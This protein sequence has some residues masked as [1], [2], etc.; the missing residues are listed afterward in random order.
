MATSPALP[1]ITGNVGP[2]P[3]SSAPAPG[4]QQN[5]LPLLPGRAQQ[6]D[7]I[8]TKMMANGESDASI[9][10]VVHD[11]KSLY[12]AGPPPAAPAPSAPPPD[13]LS[14]FDKVSSFAAGFDKQSLQ[15]LNP[16]PLVKALLQP[17]DTYEADAQ[18]R[19]KILDQ[20]GADFHQGNYGSAAIH[21]LDGMVP[22][23]GPMIN[24]I[25][26]ASDAGDPERFGRAVANLA[27]FKTA[28][29]ALGAA[30]SAVVKGAGAA[31]TAAMNAIKIEPQL[32]P[33]EASAVQYGADNGVQMPTSVQTGSKVAANAENILQNLP[34]ASGVAK[35]ARAEETR[36]LG[37]AGANEVDQLGAQPGTNAPVPTKLDAGEAL[38]GQLDQ[39]IAEHHAAAGASYDQL[40]SIENQPQFKANV[41]TGTKR[42]EAGID[43][44]GNP[45]YKNVPV[46][47]DVQLPVPLRPVK[48]ALKP[49]YDRMMRQMP[50]AQQQASAGL[51][52]LSNIVNGPDFESASIT[53]ENLGAIKQIA[54][55]ATSPVGQGLAKAA[56]KELDAAVRKAVAR[57]GPD[58]T[59]ALE[60]GRAST[61]AK[62]GA[63]EVKDSLPVEPV[64][65]VTK[66][67]APGDRNIKLLRSV[68]EQSPSHIASLAQAAV[69]GLL[70]QVTAEAGMAKA[71]T[72]LTAWQKLGPETKAILFKGREKGITDFFTL[73]KKMAENP[74]PSGTASVVALGKAGLLLF[75]KPLFA[76]PMLLSS[77]ALARV[78]FTPTG[79][80]NLIAGMKLPLKSGAIGA[81][82]SA[83][84][85]KAAGEPGPVRTT[86]KGQS[87]TAENAA[88]IANDGPVR[89]G[90]TDAAGDGGAVSAPAGGRAQGSGG[91]G[92]RSAD[93]IVPVPGKSGAGYRAEYKLRELSDI[94]ASHNGNSFSPNPKYALQN[95]RDYANVVNQRKV[96]DWS[97]RAEFRPGELVNDNPDATSGPIVTD[98]QGQV[99]GGNGRKMILDRVH[100]G[101]PDGAAAYRALLKA[102]AEQF[103]LDPA[104]VDAM[105]QPVLTRE[106]A[107]AAL[108]DKQ[109]AVTDF[110]KKGTADLTPGERAIADSRRV[111]DATLDD[112]AARLDAAGPKATVAD[113]LAGKAGGEALQKL[114]ADGVISPQEQASLVDARS[115]ELTKAGRE[116]ISQLMI[117]R[118]FA[119][120]AQLDRMALSA[121][122]KLERIAAPL[123]QVEAKPAWNLTPDVR[124]AV[125][126]SDQARKL[127]IKSVADFIAQDGLFGKDKY[128]PNAIILAKAL[129]TS[130]STELTAAARQYA[131]DAAYADKGPTLMG[132]A[133]TPK[134]SFAA[135]FGALKSGAEVDAAKVK[136]GGAAKK[137]AAKAS[138]APV[139]PTVTE[140]K[141][142]TPPATDKALGELGDLGKA[143]L[144]RFVR[145]R[146]FIPEKREQSPKKGNNPRKKDPF[147]QLFRR[148]AL[149]LVFCALGRHASGQVAAPLPLS[150]I[151]FSDANGV[152]LAGGLVYTC[153]AGSSC[154]GAPLTSYSNATGTA[155]TNPIVLNSGGFGDFWLGVAAYK[156]VVQDLNGVQQ[157]SIDNITST[158]ALAAAAL[159]FTATGTGAVT[160]TV[161][162]KL[163][164]IVNGA[165]Y[166]MLCNG[167]ADDQPAL[168]RAISAPNVGLVMLP[169]SVSGC[170]ISESV[171]LKYGVD[172]AGSSPYLSTLLAGT[173]GMTMLSGTVASLSTLSNFHLSAGNLANV[174]G[175]SLV[176]TT[177]V[178][179]RDIYIDTGVSTG[180]TSNNSYFLN[181]ENV[182][183][184]GPLTY[185]FALD[186]A[187]N[188]VKLHQCSVNATVGGIV[189]VLITNSI[190][191]SVDGGTFEGGSYFLAYN[192]QA[193][194]FTNNYF[195]DSQGLTQAEAWI[196][197]GGDEGTQPTPATP[198]DNLTANGVAITGNEFNGG[199]NYAVK[200]GDVS[201]V[202][203]SGN[204]VNTALGAWEMFAGGSAYKKGIDIGANSYLGG[205]SN[206][207]GLPSWYPAG[208]VVYNGNPGTENSLETNI[209]EDKFQPQVHHPVAEPGATHQDPESVVVYY[210]TTF[211]ALMGRRMDSSGNL[212]YS[213]LVPPG[214]GLCV[215]ARTGVD[216]SPVSCFSYQT[217]ANG[218]DGTQ[219]NFYAGYRFVSSRYGALANFG[220]NDTTRS[221]YFST[222]LL[223]PFHN[224][225]PTT[226]TPTVDIYDGTATTG[227]T[228]LSMRFGAG[229]GTNSPFLIRNAADTAWVLRALTGGGFEVNGTAG[230]SGTKTA[231]SCVL[232]LVGGVVTTITGC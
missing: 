191:V 60:Q 210:D 188:S 19:I 200:L 1:T 87:T 94:Q 79:A 103:G 113:V 9:T 202:S 229:Q 74:N 174:T 106:I 215:N 62:Y 133:P 181:L 151:Q 90:T 57:A 82:V 92:V 50:V 218:V 27:S 223:G 157:Y 146:P 43:E 186:A 213:T 158:A 116:R 67:L 220:G 144:D 25:G 66:L 93:T 219:A 182:R 204:S 104:A 163:G 7:G 208:V 95:D 152:P 214:G 88:T 28:P 222:I 84:I 142:A 72:A 221:F 119:E 109:K 91:G 139:A 154:P 98:A 117:G 212:T 110:N 56:V 175:I 138:I 51:K 136:V 6:L 42:V 120:P 231:G 61:I 32:D 8:I 170:K 159:N 85:L 39:N 179:L 131:Q 194:S 111:S 193:L 167:T 201:G 150:H 96:V 128:S 135:S 35:A 55:D 217:A 161:A 64:A 183:V 71:Q 13:A 230:F 211:H 54:R 156:I 132:D 125:D 153:A 89:S 166:G 33:A 176:N 147:M 48:L 97:S 44:V 53:D 137:A 59:A 12:S 126:L 29:E 49:I 207:G 21:A 18:Q 17:Y 195:E 69:Q 86:P 10:S 130:K 184:Y 160:R 124:A 108:P 206:G 196:A 75:T 100:T 83:D 143:A 11:F 169:V 197:I 172:V 203:I 115:G 141:A 178:S 149:A 225:L 165:D 99:L 24:E 192:D 164:D 38:H 112:M 4:D 140:A 114:I 173:A 68:A 70:D 73:A 63:Q 190:A 198:W 205:G 189:A 177:G 155:N 121:R 180:F 127:G 76:V 5:Q 52:A 77:R 22:I 209:S 30:A 31:S 81:K 102:K 40:R 58:A 26:A 41:Q 45:T 80:R 46:H 20:A 232:T 134:E 216:N 105:K 36:T 129:A 34:F 65:L 199:A 168:M 23:L 3:A 226:I 16:I 78:L 227:V 47:E 228:Q 123:A 37:A 122:A 107:D 171:I 187:S 224:L 2:L 15:N 162:A 101:N 148:A 185:G 14:T 145:S 118:Y